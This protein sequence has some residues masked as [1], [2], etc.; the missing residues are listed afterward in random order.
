M[1]R[2]IETHRARTHIKMKF[3][4]ITIL[5]SASM[6]Q[7]V[8]IESQEQGQAYMGNAYDSYYPAHAQGYPQEEPAFKPLQNRNGIEA[9]TGFFDISGSYATSLVATFLF[10][11]GFILVIELVLGDLNII[12]TITGRSARNLFENGSEM[13]AKVS[14]QKIADSVEEVYSAIERYQNRNNPR[15]F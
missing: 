7:Q 14:P 12:K 2:H 15:S 13:F 9:R 3:I 4:I 8:N 11:M 5:V 10:V 1:G 6:A